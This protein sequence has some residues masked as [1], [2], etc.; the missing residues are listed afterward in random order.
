MKQPDQQAVPAHTAGHYREFA[1]IAV[2]RPHFIC[3][4]NH[5]SIDQASGPVAVFPDGCVDVFWSDGKL[6]VAGPDTA[7]QIIDHS[8]KDVVGIRF[9]PGAASN[10]LGIPMAELVNRRVDLAELWGRRAE[11]LADRLH[12]ADSIDETTA[13]LQ[14]GLAEMARG[15]AQ[16]DKAMA[17][18]FR[19]LAHSNCGEPIADLAAALNVGERTLRRQFLHHFGYGPK[20]LARILRFQRF[21]KLGR[22]EPQT[23]I[24]ALAF[25]AN[26]ADQAHLSR[27]SKSLS[28]LS[29]SALLQHFAA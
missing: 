5:L 26:Y 2:L 14:D 19:R 17:S 12:A 21:L 8:L 10:W 23:G 1:P 16:P 25:D 13:R 22:C 24:G 3:I 11:T 4:W 6:T 28:G 7:P 29:P 18:A 27:E 9:A 20:T 15:A